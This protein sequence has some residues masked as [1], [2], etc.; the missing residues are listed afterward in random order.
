MLIF[1]AFINYMVQAYGQYSASIVAVNTFARSLGSAS[2]PLFTD[3]MFEAMGIGGGGSLIAGIATVLAVIPFL[4]FRYGKRIRVK[5]KHTDVDLSKAGEEH[6][7]SY[8]ETEGEVEDLEV[9]E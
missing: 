9:A 4:F 7:T 8:E 6:P 3:Y 1:V 5:S 2:A